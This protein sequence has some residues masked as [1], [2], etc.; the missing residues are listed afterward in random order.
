[1]FILRL[2]FMVWCNKCIEAFIT[3]MSALFYSGKHFLS[4]QV[5]ISREGVALKERFREIWKFVI[6]AC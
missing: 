5:G 6:V 2:K 3:E 4:H 1:M